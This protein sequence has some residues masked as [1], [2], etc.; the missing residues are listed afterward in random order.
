MLKLTYE[1]SL[2]DGSIQR[3]YR[4]KNGKTFFTVSKESKV[5]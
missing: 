2:K 3:T 4:D 5:I 1:R